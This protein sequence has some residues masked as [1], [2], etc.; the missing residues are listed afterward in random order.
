MCIRDSLKVLDHDINRL[1]VVLDEMAAMVIYMHRSN[2]QRIRD[3]KEYRLSL[4]HI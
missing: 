2:I 3:G 4:I 1:G